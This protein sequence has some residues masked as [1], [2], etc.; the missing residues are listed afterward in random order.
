MLKKPTFA[1]NMSGLMARFYCIEG[2]HSTIVP[3]VIANELAFNAIYK[4]MISP[5]S[6]T[7]TTT[8]RFFLF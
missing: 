1:S 3:T 8:V 7:T 6:E 2:E 4:I 5:I